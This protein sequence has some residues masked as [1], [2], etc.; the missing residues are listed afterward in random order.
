M[1]TLFDLTEQEVALCKAVRRR[2]G[3]S[4]AYLRL[5]DQT[6]GILRLVPD[7]TLRWG[8]TQQPAERAMREAAVQAAGGDLR[9]AVAQLAAQYPE[10]LEGDGT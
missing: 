2:P 7:A 6:G 10:G 8:A 9:Q 4:E 1:R 5:P 3:W